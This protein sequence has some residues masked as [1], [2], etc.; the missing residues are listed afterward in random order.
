[1]IILA[2]A[3]RMDLE[4]GVGKEGRRQEA[5]IHSGEHLG[6]QKHAYREGVLDKGSV[7]PAC[8]APAA[9]HL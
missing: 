1:M 7:S 5:S 3:C 4:V 9:P 6:V 8:L 2:A